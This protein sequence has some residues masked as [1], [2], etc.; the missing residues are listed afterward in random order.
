[1]A[2]ATIPMLPQAQSL[3]GDEQI[4]IVQAGAS[5]RTTVFDIAALGFGGPP[6]PTGPTTVA[7][8][9]APTA[10]LRS[11]VTDATVT[12]FGTI[13]VGGGANTVPV[14][15]DGLAWRIG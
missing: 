9:G 5:A 1:M 7:A 3:V 4:E 15:A 8:L 2:N 11:M 13:V 10:A 6:A 12:T 14:Y